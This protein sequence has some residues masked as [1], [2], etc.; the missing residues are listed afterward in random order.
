[1][2]ALDDLMITGALQATNRMDIEMLLNPVKESQNIQGTSD[3]EIFNAVMKCRN[4]LEVA[5][6]AGGDDVDDTSPYE[7]IPSC[8]EVLQ[9]ASV[10]NQYVQNIN[11][12][13]AHKVEAVFNSLGR[14]TRYESQS[15]KVD[16][17]IT[18]FFKY[19]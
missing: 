18:D 14:Q 6:N 5:P 11:D 4:A 19:S 16:I 9:A 12:P 13:L 10:I 8:R 2:A 7:S 3:K 15:D 17:R 1:M